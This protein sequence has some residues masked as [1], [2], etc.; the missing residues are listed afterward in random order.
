MRPKQFYL[1]LSCCILTLLSGCKEEDESPLRFYNSEYEVPMGGRRYLGLESGNGDYSLEVK[2]TRIAS[3]G[4]ETG[5]TGVPAGRMIYVTGILT[6]QTYLKVTDNATQETCTLP[7]KVVD[8]YESIKLFHRYSSNLPNGGANLLPGIS[9]IFLIN[10]HARDVYFFKQGEQATAFS[11]GLILIG[12]GNYKLEKEEGNNEKA[13]LTL[14]F[15]E[16]ATT[17]A[18]DHKFIVRGN[19]YIFHR[20]DKNLNLDWNTPSIGETRTSPAPPPS[21]TLE[22]ITEGESGTGRQ[23]GF[24]FSEQEIPAGILP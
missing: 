13:I 14:T 20:L 9:D 10:N 18:S 22:E 6:G 5:W 1:L 8:N 16:D 2:D 11:S 7:I 4:T 21:F 24:T 15:S 17:S 23:L 19:A 12:R 3:A